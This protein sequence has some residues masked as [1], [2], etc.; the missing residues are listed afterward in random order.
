MCVTCGAWLALH[1]WDQLSHSFDASLLVHVLLPVYRNIAR[2]F[3][4]Y[5]FEGE[6]QKAETP[7]G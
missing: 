2:F 3:V 7:S 4:E 5:M 6:E 1:L